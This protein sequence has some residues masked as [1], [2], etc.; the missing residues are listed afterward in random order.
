MAIEKLNFTGAGQGSS[1]SSSNNVSGYSS[2]A[3]RFLD[4][5]D[6]L[7]KDQIIR[8]R[9]AYAK[10][11][12][13]IADKR[14]E[15]QQAIL[16]AER[17]KKANTEKSLLDFQNQ[18]SNYETSGIVDA[19]KGIALSNEY[20]NLKASGK[21]DT[22]ASN[23]IQNRINTIEQQDKKMLD[24]SPIARYD[25]INSLKISGDGIDPTMLITL[26]N[27][28]LKELM[29]AEDKKQDRAFDEKKF[30]QDVAESNRNYNL[31]MQQFNYN[32]NE[33][34]KDKYGDLISSAGNNLI[35]P[36]G[37]K[38]EKTKEVSNY[39]I[40]DQKII[41]DKLANSINNDKPINDAYNKITNINKFVS[42]DD[43]SVIDA[44]KD[45]EN[46]SKNKNEN[47]AS[48][49]Q[50]IQDIRQGI[51]NKLDKNEIEDRQNETIMLKYELQKQYA[52]SPQELIE[53]SN[54]QK[55]DAKTKI[56]DYQTIIDN[57]L[58]LY[59][60]EARYGIEMKDK[61][62]VGTGEYEYKAETP[63]SYASSAAKEAIEKAKK[64]GLYSDIE[65]AGIGQ[66]AYNAAYNAQESAIEKQV[67]KEAARSEKAYERAND[68]QKIVL[69]NLNKNVENAAK[70]V[71]ALVDSGEA[72]DSQIE[73]ANAKLEEAQTKVNNYNNSIMK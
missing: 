32:K 2:I 28:R 17:D 42:K 39:T 53:I 49:R 35:G 44:E 15:E 62:L 23:I 31:Q 58:S 55:D 66:K 57:R 51:S 9:D 70:V 25:R 7:N 19:N 54:R 34:L 3:D 8:E 73:E 26:K 13:L 50:K 10:E 14:Y 48:I 68:R 64:S 63:S 12:D 61:K 5:G 47:I 20:D 11:R 41:N 30:N 27:Q 71:K 46:I 60:K 1:S 21:S 16:K 6:Q 18:M 72:S 29:D 37:E 45:F 40:D 56:K 67:A 52:K 33:K 24:E 36:S 38:I 43:Y 65:I 22:E 59:D 69:D 4:F